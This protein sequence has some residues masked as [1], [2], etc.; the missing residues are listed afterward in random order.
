M[1]IETGY[2]R[3]VMPVECLDWLDIQANGNYADL[4]F[5]GGG[6]SALILEKLQTGHLFA[7]DQDPQ[8]AKNVLLSE[9]FTLIPSNFKN[10][11]RELNQRQVFEIDGILADLGVSSHQIDTAERGF[12]YR[13]PEAILDMRMNTNDGMTAADILNDWPENEIYR[14]FAHYGE[15]G[16]SGKMARAIVHY[17]KHKKFETI[18][19]LLSALRDFLPA[20]H[21]AEL[22]S[23][24]F[25]ALRIAVNAELESLEEMLEQSLKVLKPG[26]RMVIMSYHSLE[27]RLVKRFFQTGNTAGILNKDFYGN[28]LT[29]FKVL[30]KK[31]ILASAEEI[32][33]NPRARSAKLRV[34][35]KLSDKK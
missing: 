27:D 8:A 15:V 16:G 4:T 5:G 33:E 29:P 18:E 28:P 6:H 13:F 35:E 3:P 24:I 22:L 7:F 10:I 14:V 34:A 23:P 11:A 2:H 21:T 30:T 25:Q 12:S 17:R 19:D 31:P 20:K 9:K 1:R 26:G 32:K